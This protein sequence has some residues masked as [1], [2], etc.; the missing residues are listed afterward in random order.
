[1]Q[2]PFP[3]SKQQIIEKV[4]SVCSKKDA[5]V[6]EICH[7]KILSNITAKHYVVIVP[8]VEVDFFKSI[9]SNPYEVISESTYSSSFNSLR[10]FLPK[11]QVHQYGWY[12]QQLIKL[13]AIQ[14][15]SEEQIALIWD[16]DTVPVQPLEFMN[17]NNQLI[18]YQGTEH[19]QPYFDCIK[20][21]T[22]L[23]KIVNF[24]FIAQCFP[25]RVEWLHRFFGELEKKHATTW[26]KA[27]L[28]QIDFNGGNGFSE[29]ET[30]GTFISHYYEN[31]ICYSERPWLRL[32]NSLIGHAAFL[33]DYIHKNKPI[34]YD[35]ISFEK[36]D[37]IKPYFFKVTIPYFF[38]ITLP[39]FFKNYLGV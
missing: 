30:L 31:Q 32:G 10:A 35:F 37:R 15:M 38:K 14:E 27:I 1:M 11:N 12:L 3:T 33:D 39:K 20:Q 26:N 17:K 23:E 21:L 4:I 5:E 25:I 24:S 28:S 16:A 7:K 34:K 19:H 6:W 2:Q 29:Y 22:G 13:A 18:Y 9:T 36:W 8:E